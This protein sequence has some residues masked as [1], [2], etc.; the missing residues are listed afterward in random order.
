MYK[1]EICQKAYNIYLIEGRKEADDLFKNGCMVNYRE[2][3]YQQFLEAGCDPENPWF[4]MFS[5]K[6]DYYF[7]KATNE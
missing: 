6:F 3:T 5:E 7:N 4:T 2:F 1:E